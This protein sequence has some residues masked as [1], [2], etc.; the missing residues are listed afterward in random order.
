MNAPPIVAYV[1]DEM[2]VAIADAQVEFV[3]PEHPANTFVA[4][5]GP[6][7]AVSAPLTVGRWK[8][9]LAAP[10]FGSKVSEITVT[11]DG[12]PSMLRLLSDR[13][14]GYARPK[15][16]C[17]GEQIELCLHAAE[18]FRI[19]LMRH[20]FVRA[21]VGKPRH[22]EAF[23][24]LGD[25]QLIP[26][27][28]ISASGAQWNRYGCA[29][30]PSG[31]LFWEA[32]Q[33]SGLY[34]FHM[35]ARSGAHF[36][37]PVVVAPSAPTAKLAVLI[38]EYNWNAYNDFGGRS[39]YVAAGQLP[40]RPSIAPR[41]ESPWFRDTG[42]RWWNRED[43][44]PLSFDRPA[45]FNGVGEHEQATDPMWRIGT[46]HLAPGEWR[47]L[48]WLEREGIAHDTYADGQLDDGSL[49]LDDYDALLIHTHPEYWTREM[50]TRTKEW[51][52]ERGGNLMYLGGNG[53]NCMVELTDDGTAMIARNG[54]VSEWV[55]VRSFED[56]PEARMPSRFGAQVENEA[57]LL[58]VSTTLTGMDTTAPYRV[59]DADHWSL[60]GLDVS[61]GDMFGLD[62]L[63][64]RCPPG[65]ASGHETDKVNEFS[66][67]NIELIAKGENPDN[68]GGE[69]VHFD[70]PSGGAVFSVGSISWPAALLVDEGV[71]AVTANVIRR[72]SGERDP[73]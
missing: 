66:P 55:N 18:P 17:A 3:D 10:G 69:M 65:G 12:E 34:F 54:D 8:V 61:A 11:A 15:S 33:E 52:F 26:D 47:M 1:S 44:D 9:S 72:F 67:A 6:S 53:I 5:T 7:G 45:L 24:P 16:V 32:P 4:R 71:S 51:V 56:V 42:G 29:Q 57:H 49:D 27:G 63:D 2:Y 25:R 58:G 30:P 41:Q 46:E 60:A 40:D 31:A 22:Y 28:D 21:P 43:Y 39:N 68:G 64:R 70:T 37:F 73:S 50:Y 20:G 23:A 35:S 14:Y 59:L 13:M 36:A 19:Q 48:A 38:S 62:S